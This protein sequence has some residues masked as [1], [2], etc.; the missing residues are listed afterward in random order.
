MENRKNIDWFSYFLL[1][2]IS[3]MSHQL[4]VIV[5]FMKC[6]VIVRWIPVGSWESLMMLT[7]VLLQFMKW[8]F[9]VSKLCNFWGYHKVEKFILHFINWTKVSKFWKNLK[10]LDLV[11]V[12]ELD[13]HFINWTITLCECDIYNWQ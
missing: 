11:A 13:V 1:Q 8:M 5:Q 7:E 3:H 10:L 9:L 12:H 2:W 4:S 6:N